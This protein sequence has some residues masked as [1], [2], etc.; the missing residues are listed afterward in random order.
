MCIV[1]IKSMRGE[2]GRVSDAGGEDVLA[3]AARAVFG[4]GRLFGRRS[5]YDG[6]A[7]ATSGGVE[8][9]VIAVVQ[10]I[11][12]VRAEGSG[13]VG[14]GAVADHLVLDPSTASRIVAGAVDRGYV[15]RV[16]GGDGRRVG[17]ALT[18]AGEGLAREVRAYQQRVFLD[19]TRSFSDTER[20]EFARLFSAFAREVARGYE[21]AHGRTPP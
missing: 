21:A 4:L 1:H 2:I 16:A 15:Q 10:A 13:P 7:G 17:L 9:S 11:E 19:A 20:R 14:V 18:D 6:R 12:S 3:D 5:A 8:L